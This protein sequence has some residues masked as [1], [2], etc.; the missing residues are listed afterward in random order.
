MAADREDA[1]PETRHADPETRLRQALVERGSPELAARIPLGTGTKLHRYLR[2]SLAKARVDDV[3]AEVS[4]VFSDFLVRILGRFKRRG[5]DDIDGVGWFFEVAKS[6]LSAFLAKRADLWPLGI[7]V[8]IDAL[9][10]G[11]IERLMEG[12]EAIDP[13]AGGD[14]EVEQTLARHV[15]KLSPRERE[16]LVYALVFRYKTARIAREMGL[17]P[18]SVGTLRS[19]ALRKLRNH[20]L[21]ANR[22]RR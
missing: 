10:P 3:D 17:K 22:R 16:I 13:A 11:A 14:Q 9:D 12:R 15:G 18:S 2:R 4:E 5:A 1:D 8:D 21:D 7:R 6:A 19:Q 20:L